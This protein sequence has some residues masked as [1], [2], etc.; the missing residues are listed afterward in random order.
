MAAD[1]DLLRGF[2][3]SAGRAGRKRI[4]GLFRDRCRVHLFPEVKVHQVEIG[5]VPGGVRQ[6]QGTLDSRVHAG[7]LVIEVD[8]LPVRRIGQR[9][10]VALKN[11]GVRRRA[12]RRYAGR[13]GDD[14]RLVDVL[15]V[16]LERDAAALALGQFPVQL[17]GHA[18]DK[19]GQVGRAGE[20]DVGRRFFNR[21]LLIAQPGQVVEGI[22]CG[23]VMLRGEAV[24]RLLA[25]VRE[26]SLGV[27]LD[28]A[29]QVGEIQAFAHHVQ[30]ILAARGR[31]F[32]PLL[33]VAD[34]HRILDLDHFNDRILPVFRAHA[35]QADDVLARHLEQQ[36][37]RHF[38]GL[39]GGLLYPHFSAVPGLGFNPQGKVE[40]IAVE[41]GQGVRVH[42][43]EFAGCSSG[44]LARR[45]CGG[46]W[47]GAGGRR[48]RGGWVRPAGG[49]QQRDDQDDQD[50]RDGPKARV[51]HGSLLG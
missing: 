42:R 20:P 44:R 40:L 8:D 9:K 32:P 15:D 22:F 1:L 5:A 12:A 50:E 10:A 46:G 39:G 4:P 7:G 14:D 6:C 19:H 13:C 33:V 2:Q 24:Y 47:R 23:A 30:Y 37:P 45:W 11:F 29:G 27:L 28:A 18:D 35:A 31:L 34:P 41:P 48:R 21:H 26:S 25:N 3:V 38:G 51:C 36:P 49:P 43:G 17:D 16:Q